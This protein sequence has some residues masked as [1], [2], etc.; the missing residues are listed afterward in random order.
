MAKITTKQHLNDLRH[1]KVA[2][3]LEAN[4]NS[5][6]ELFALKFQ[7]AM[8]SLE[9]THR[10]NQ[11]KKEIA[12]IE[13]IL[14]EKRLAGEN[15]NRVVKGDYS[16][17]VVAATKASKILRKKQIDKLAALNQT[18]DLPPELQAKLKELAP[19]SLAETKDVSQ[20]TKTSKTTKLG[21]GATKSRQK[22]KGEN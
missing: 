12:R 3:L 7:A 9:K 2:E 5:R 14:G 15:I 22:V 19:Q 21:V 11:L 20:E 8:G 6:A 16:K 18:Q 1:K 17:A 10:I 13:L 4:E